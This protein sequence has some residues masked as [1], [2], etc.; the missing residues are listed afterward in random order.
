MPQ[1]DPLDGGIR[2]WGGSRVKGP[3]IRDLHTLELVVAGRDAAHL[4]ESAFACIAIDGT[5]FIILDPEEQR[6]GCFMTRRTCAV[7]DPQLD[8]LD[9]GP[10]LSIGSVLE[11]GVRDSNKLL[12]LRGEGAVMML[13]TELGIV[14]DCG[15]P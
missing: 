4:R 2:V 14:M 15:R 3:V 7:H 13:T 11:M 1:S 5:T 8:P 9:G 12:V 10:G 6:V